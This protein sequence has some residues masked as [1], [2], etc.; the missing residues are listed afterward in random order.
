[1]TEVRKSDL[2]V[3]QIVS[4]YEMEARGYQVI[5]VTDISVYYYKPQTNWVRVR[6]GDSK[7]INIDSGG[8]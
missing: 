8:Y 4:Q 7:I 3:G 1:M 6:K 2:K 5:S